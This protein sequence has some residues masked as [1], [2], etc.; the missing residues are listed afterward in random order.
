VAQVEKVVSKVQEDIAAVPDE[1]HVGVSEVLMRLAGRL[2][3]LRDQIAAWTVQ[4]AAALSTLQQRVAYMRCSDRPSLDLDVAIA[5]H[6]LRSGHLAAARAVHRAALDETQRSLVDMDALT[7]VHAAAAALRRHDLSP[8]LAW[9]HDNASRL[10]RVDSV[11]E[12]ALRR[13]EFIELVRAGH[14]SAAM[15]HAGTHLAPAAKAAAA[16]A[17]EREKERERDGVVA[18]DAGASGRAGPTVTDASGGRTSPGAACLTQLQ[19]VMSVLAFGDPATCGVPDVERMFADAA[20]E[21]LDRHLRRDAALALGL[22]A[23]TPLEV[24][25]AVGLTALKTLACVP[26]AGNSGLERAVTAGTGN[27]VSPGSGAAAVGPPRSL[28]PSGPARPAAA[29]AAYSARTVTLPPRAEHA[30][31]ACHPLYFAA[32]LPHVPHCRRSVSRLLCPVTRE[33][34]DENN[35][36]VVLPNG[37]MYGRR[38]VQLLSSADHQQVLCPRTGELFRLADTRRAYIM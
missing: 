38:T 37:R 18:G 30:C 34:M 14:R 22:P 12:F 35:P 25:V 16:A 21:T 19:Q 17:A 15:D 8:A 1:S 23:R 7:A 24:H 3:E 5:D 31:P 33:A 4:E 32:V 6:L 27:S 29:A 13:Q 20:W 10:R 26:N 28:S 36:P 2:T 11:L 9:V